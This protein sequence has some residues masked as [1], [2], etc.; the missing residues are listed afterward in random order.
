MDLIDAQ[1][2]PVIGRK[3]LEGLSGERLIAASAD[4]AVA[5][6]DAVGVRAANV[7]WRDLEL[8][9][10]HVERYPD[11][12]VAVP[13]AISLSLDGRFDPVVT[14]ADPPDEYVA[15]IAESPGFVGIRMGISYGRLIDLYRAGV[16]EPYYAAAEKHGVPVFITLF[17]YAAEFEP[18]IRAHSKLR[19]IIDHVGLPTPPSGSTP[20][21][22]I[23]G[24][25]HLFA[26]LPG[27]IALARYPNVAV[28]FTAVPSLSAEPYPFAD[29][30]P[31]MRK[32]IDA[33]GADRMM[34][35]SDFTRCVSLHSY[36]ESVDF[37]VLTDQLSETEKEA[38]A[39]KTFLDWVGSPIGWQQEA[40]GVRK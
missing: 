4:L 10:G 32:L 38:M 13:A 7:N 19:F 3:A 34:W 27:V 30:W 31:H 36:R 40:A 39:S 33:F 1:I 12:F 15:R 25:A 37:F 23:K 9:K 2:H 5:S 11:R 24:G 18:T 6:L 20:G 26:G 16:H 29:V 8:L 22:P 17:D 21:K 35:G 28:K 14:H